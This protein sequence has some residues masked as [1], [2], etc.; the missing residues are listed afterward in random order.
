MIQAVGASEDADRAA[1]ARGA[2]VD[3]LLDSGRITTP[4]VEAAFR[5]VPRHAF[6]PAGTPLEEVYAVDR[7]VVTKRDEHGAAL[8]SVSANYIQARMIEQAGV[9]RGM[10][11][12]EI[13]SGGYNAALLAEVVGD[14]GR[15]VSVDI[16][17]DVTE[18]TTALLRA[19]GYGDRVEVLQVDAEHGVPGHEV[20]DRILVTVGAWDIAPAWLAALAAD[21]VIVVPLRM[22]GVTRTI[23]FHRHGDHLVSS[24]S[25]V[26]GF[27]PMQGT[28][29][30]RTGSC[31]CPT[32]RAG[33]SVSS[34]TPVRRRTRLSS[35][36]SWPPRGWRRGRA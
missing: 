31:G 26:A 11:V 25:E 1:D 20:F 34:S 12:L 28:A 14:E 24:S 27:V 22:N 18:R 35:T 6:V 13:G 36:V 3:K 29:R 7:A 32:V 9:G 21:G 19:T 8:S 30:V 16:D 15:V 33:A 23:A 10:R 4:V 5:A 2:L 17:P